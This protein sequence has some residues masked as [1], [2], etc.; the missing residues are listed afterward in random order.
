MRRLNDEEKKAY[1]EGYQ[2][3]I[4]GGSVEGNPFREGTDLH[5]IWIN[6]Y[7]DSREDYWEN[8]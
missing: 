6:G 5:N 4:E 1:E 8:R 7:D 2:H 3:Q